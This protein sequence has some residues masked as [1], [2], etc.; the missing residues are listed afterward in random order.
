MMKLLRCTDFILCHENF[1]I[2][3]VG[4]INNIFMSLLSIRIVFH[5]HDLL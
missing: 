2:K 3:D 5:S 1:F 4:F